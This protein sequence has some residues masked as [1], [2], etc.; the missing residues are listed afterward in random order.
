MLSQRN[1]KAKRR[2][3]NGWE[4]ISTLTDLQLN[5]RYGLCVLIDLKSS[6]WFRR[7]SHSPWH[8]KWSEHL[9]P[10]LLTLAAIMEAYMY[11]Y[12][13]LYTHTPVPYHKIK[14][15]YCTFRTLCVSRQDSTGKRRALQR[16][17]AH[18]LDRI[19]RRNDGWISWD[20]CFSTSFEFI[21]LALIFFS[22]NAV[23]LASWVRSPNSR[24]SLLFLSLHK[25]F[26]LW[27]MS[28]SIWVAKFKRDG[29]HSNG[30]IPPHMRQPTDRRTLLL[31]ILLLIF[32]PT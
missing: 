7:Q 6:P 27:S 10:N 32:H 11:Q 5:V 30:S 18:Y 22:F 9:I 23:A 21:L 8:W 15:L 14:S 20:K 4:I 25:Q 31:L 17:S 2:F 1:P 12:L 29:I 28:V 13:Y 24:Y 16:Q 3:K 19:I 26:S